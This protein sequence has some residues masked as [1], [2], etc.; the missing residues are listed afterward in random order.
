MVQPDDKIPVKG[1][2]LGFLKGTQ[3]LSTAF[4]LIGL[5]P[6]LLLF[7]MMVFVL[8][9]RTLDFKTFLLYSFLLVGV[10]RLFAW[11]SIIRCR[12]NTK[13]SLFRTLA[14]IVV[15]IDILYKVLF[16]G[17]YVNSYF[18]KEKDQQELVAI[19]EKCKQEVS[20]R[21]QIPLEEL[22]TNYKK[23]YSGGDIYYAVKHET[24]YFECYVRPD[25]IEIRHRKIRSPKNPRI[26]TKE[27]DR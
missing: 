2:L 15:I 26:D 13:S 23:S 6:A 1:G 17:M 19:F 18:E 27:E 8:Q 24:D 12:K 5:I 4:W 21:Y 22:E 7:L 25:S 20:K 11:T 16:T 9:S 3:P 14:I 10:H